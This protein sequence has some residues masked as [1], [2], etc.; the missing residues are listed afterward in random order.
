MIATRERGTK[1]ASNCIW[2]SMAA[3]C[4]VIILLT[5]CAATDAAEPIFKTG[6]YGLNYT[7]ESTRLRAALLTGYDKF[8][9]PSS[10][11][12][13]QRVDFSSGGTDVFLNVRFFKVQEVKAAAGSMRIKVWVKMSWYDT[14][15]QVR[16]RG[17]TKENICG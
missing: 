5:F 17:S 11:R 1:E 3:A 9:P 13:L 14:R 10:D 2:A 12:T 4:K 6:T 8:S 7:L 15:L 16:F